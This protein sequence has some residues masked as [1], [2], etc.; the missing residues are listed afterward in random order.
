MHFNPIYSKRILLLRRRYQLT[1]HST[2]FQK[3]HIMMTYKSAAPP[4]PPV[5]RGTR[6]QGL[7]RRDAEQPKHLLSSI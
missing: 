6:D 2:V 1:L 3:V 5:F 4:R 7:S